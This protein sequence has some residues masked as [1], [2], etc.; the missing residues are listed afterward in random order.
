[1]TAAHKPARLTVEEYLRIENAAAFKSEFYR[2]EMFA[3]AGAAGQ[4][5][6]IKDNLVRHLGNRLD[7]SGCRTRSSDQRVR[8]PTGL[9]T[10]PDVVIICGTPEY[11]PLDSM[12]LTNPRV[13][14]EV[15]SPSTAGYDR[16]TKLDHYQHLPTVAEVMLVAH[17]RWAA[18][19]FTRQPDG[20]WVRTVFADPAGELELASLNVRIPLADVY[21]DTGVPDHPPLRAHHPDPA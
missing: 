12:T 7:G 17:D 11:D 18:E 20:R 3:M 4:H 21:R 6:D 8:V 5:S 9:Y 14:I 13:V 19:V 16:G 10:Y 2:G 1:M 15:L